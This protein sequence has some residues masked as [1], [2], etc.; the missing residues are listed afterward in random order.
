MSSFFSLNDTVTMEGIPRILSHSLRDRFKASA[1]SDPWRIECEDAGWG[2][3]RIAD[4]HF[5]S[6]SELHP[7]K[8]TIMRIGVKDNIHCQ[9]FATRLGLHR[10]RQY[11]NAS[12][13]VLENIPTE[14]ITCKTQL[15]EVT[16]GIDAGCSNP[17]F[18]GAW[19]GASSTGSAV[20]VAANI[21][22]VAIGTDSLG[23]LRIPAAACGVVSLRMTY[24]REMLTGLLPVAPSFD[25][26]GWIARTLDDLSFAMERL[27]VLRGPTKPVG[28]TFRVG[29]VAEV[30]ADPYCSPSILQTYQAL[31]RRA[32]NKRVELVEISLGEPLWNSR[33]AAWK[34]CAREAFESLS[35]V[36]KRLG[37]IGGDATLVLDLGESV[38]ANEAQQIRLSQDAIRNTMHSQM[39]AWALD[40]FIMPATPFFLPTPAVIS[41]L[42]M[43]FPNVH[44]AS[45]AAFAGYAPI[46]SV[47]GSPVLSIPISLVEN[48]QDGRKQLAFQ[49]IG[50]P[51]CERDL[52]EIGEWL[53]G[54]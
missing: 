48:G 21:C 13:A 30:L 47:L 17:R 12:A 40:A 42:P 14:H 18:P 46:A 5:R 33:V 53:T 19:S 32:T 24:D 52:L 10:Y 7:A 23:S 35:H 2:W 45:A 16:L 3:A 27:N 11:P 38:S 9:G 50:R 43:L 49:L 20:A 39:E 4:E 28:R 44:D 41:S 6:L 22:D 36:G 31:S 15:T 25:A 37:P 34:L 1:A 26:V 54:H 8:K 51:A 29:M